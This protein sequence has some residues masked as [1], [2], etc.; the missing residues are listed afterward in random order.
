MIVLMSA[1][2]QAGVRNASDGG[3][4]GKMVAK[5]QA[6]MR[7]VTKERD[8]FKTENAK[9]KADADV[10]NKEKK[11]LESDKSKMSNKLAGEKISHQKLQQRQQKTYE[12]LT[13]VVERYKV[14]NQ[15]KNGLIVELKILNDEH[16]QT[17]QQLKICGQHNSKLISSANELLDRYQNKGTFEGVFQSEGLLQFQSVEMENIVQDYE[18]KIRKEEYKE[19]VSLNN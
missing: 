10:L 6:M 8:A 15:K 3:G 2:L 7:Q 4:S 18:D 17:T 12:K 14:L 5:L 16:N 9:L 13:D 19:V 11:V 1:S